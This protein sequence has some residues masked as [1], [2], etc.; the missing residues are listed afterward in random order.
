MKKYRLLI[1]MLM[2]FTLVFSSLAPIWADTVKGNVIVDTQFAD[3]MSLVPGWGTDT[4]TMDLGSFLYSPLL[5]MD[6]KMNLYPMVAE[7]YSI[8]KDRLAYTVKLRKGWKWHD[9]VEVTAEDVK[10][11]YDT[12]LNPDANA[13]R[14]ADVIDSKLKSIEVKDKYTV[15][16]HLSTKNIWFEYSLNDNYWLPKHILGKVPVRDIQKHDYFQKPVGNGPFKFVE[17]THGERIVFE[18]YKD[19]PSQFKPKTPSDRY[20]YQIVPSQ[21][22]ALLKVQKGE[23]NFTFCSAADIPATKK[24]SNVTVKDFPDAS[25]MYISFNLRRPFF[26]DKKVRQA[27]AHAINKDALSKGVYKGYYIPASSFYPSLH[28]F[29]NSKVKTYDYSLS[30]AKQLLDE[31]GWKVGK[32]GIREKDGV[33]FKFTLLALKG[34]VGREKTC[35]FIQSSLKQLGI[36]VEVRSLEWNTMNTKYIDAKNYDA[37]YISMSQSFIPLPA[38]DFGKNGTFNSGSYYNAEVE[39]LIDVVNE[40]NSK[41]EAK[42]AMFRIQEIVQ[43]ELPMLT[44]LYPSNTYAMDKRLQDVKLIYGNYYQPAEWHVNPNY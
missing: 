20:I 3:P 38:S 15:V 43:D 11:T 31:A 22:T 42:D 34:N 40:A 4:S 44:L 9:G 25:I 29:H 14:R 10:F 1:S 39:K 17:Y 32:D 27:I 24:L 33:K 35:V 28:W 41:Q 26:S 5:D 30:K 21:A 23:A 18:P 19:Y 16:F 7:S 37:A 13:M 8:S 12:I 2:A 36:A 6:E